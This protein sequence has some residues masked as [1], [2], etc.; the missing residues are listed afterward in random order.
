MAVAKRDG[1]ETNVNYIYLLLPAACDCTG[2]T[3]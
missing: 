1:K 2:S 3:L